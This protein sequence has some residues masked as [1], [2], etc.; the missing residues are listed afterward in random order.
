MNVLARGKCAGKIV[1]AQP[2]RTQ[3]S[4]REKSLQPRLALRTADFETVAWRKSVATV[5]NLTVKSD[6]VSVLTP[7]W[8]VLQPANAK[9]V[10]TKYTT[11]RE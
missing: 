8:D 1:P 9:T 7:G 10:Q 5:R 6:T 11:S 3:A 4:L 2:V